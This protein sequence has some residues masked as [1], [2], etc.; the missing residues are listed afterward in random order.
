M[1]FFWIMLVVAIYY[2]RRGHGNTLTFGE[3]FQTGLIMTL[4]YC[5]GFTIVI[6][7]YNR[8]INPGYYDTLRDFTMKQLQDE[9]ASATTIDA[10]MKELAMTQSGSALSYLL[11]FVFATIWGIGI[12]AI[13]SAVLQKKPASA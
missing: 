1:I 11:L 6:I 13:A 12:S 5:A 8:F 7:I 2:K 4:I 9:H 10:E 3:G